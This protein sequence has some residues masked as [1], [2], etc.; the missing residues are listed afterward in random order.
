MAAST[1]IGYG[2]YTYLRATDMP[3]KSP[4]QAHLMRAAAHN[5]AFARKAG[6]PQ[7]VAREFVEADKRKAKAKSGRLSKAIHDAM[8]KHGVR[9]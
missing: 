4:E 6:V 3:S 8:D 5:A 7:H 9:D 2:A 1:R